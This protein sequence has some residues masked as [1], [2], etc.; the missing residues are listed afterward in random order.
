MDKGLA[1]LGVEPISGDA[2]SGISVRY[3]PDFEK[4]Q[5]EIS[6]LES[7]ESTAVNWNEVVDIGTQILSKK[8]KDLL[9]AC[10]VC[11]GLYEKTGYSGLSEGLVIIV[12]MVDTF[13]DGLFP[14]LK[15]KR[16]RGAAL[17]WLVGRLGALVI[18]R[19][20]E[21]GER[22]AIANCK[23]S[24][25]RLEEILTEKAGDLDIPY[26]EL[27]RPI[28]DYDADF[29]RANERQQQEDDKKKAAPAPIKETIPAAALATAGT[30]IAL[31][32]PETVSSDQDLKKALQ[33]CR[34]MLRKVAVYQSERDLSD[35]LPYRLLRV[36]IW[37]TVG[38][39]VIQNDTTQVHQIP[40]ERLTF[41]LGLVE[42][43]DDELLIKEVESSLFNAPY[44]LD[45]HRWIACALGNLGYRDA[46]QSVIAGLAEFLHR[47]PALRDYKFVGGMPFADEQTRQ[48]I[49]DE[50]L[51]GG[52][53]VSAATITVSPQVEGDGD[54]LFSEVTDAARALASTGDFG[55]AIEKLQWG[56]KQSGSRRERFQWDLHLASFCLEMGY[57][58]VSISQLEY[59]DDEVV[60]YHLEEWEPALSLQVAVL[61]LACYRKVAV[62]DEFSS[63]RKAREKQVLSRISRL[64]PATAV[65]LKKK[66]KRK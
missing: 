25:E 23:A 1:Y 66:K 33:N 40:A 35:P 36:A 61:L 24:L 50:V 4:L 49:D 65:K 3:D 42:K 32:V 48:W 26:G 59:L 9:V 22:D 11:H 31:A 51:T 53:A 41:L 5:E 13:W 29:S 47:F 21:S 56:Q 7:M 17:E 30:P 10:Y 44:W 16:A 15:R 18:K 46:Q 12:G 38:L 19:K 43:G 54:A 27:L 34:D 6:K 8:S 45:A 37:M 58:D 39:P 14:E 20:P 2:V 55:E 64:D 62:P 52:G 28:R 63:D 60:R 57:E